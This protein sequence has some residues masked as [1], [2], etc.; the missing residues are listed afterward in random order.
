MYVYLNS[1][2]FKVL[3]EFRAR[4][5]KADFVFV[6]KETGLPYKDV[7]RAFKSACKRANISDLRLHDLRHTFASRLIENG[8]DLITVKE[9]LGHSTV[10]MIERYTHPNHKQKRRAVEFLAKKSTKKP[11][12]PDELAH[13]R[14][15]DEDGPSELDVTDSI[16]I[17]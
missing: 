15:I 12:K 3:K 8:V 14:H 1:E 7:K 13:I 6:N 16:L 17:N 11:E 9:L 4:N 2:L 10:K 5:E